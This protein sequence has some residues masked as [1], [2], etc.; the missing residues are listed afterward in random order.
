MLRKTISLWRA[1][2][3]RRFGVP[4][5]LLSLVAGFSPLTATVGAHAGSFTVDQ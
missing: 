4:L 3:A 5:A 2:F 1:R